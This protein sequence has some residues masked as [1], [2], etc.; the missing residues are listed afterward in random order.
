MIN[1]LSSTCF[2]ADYLGLLLLMY[3]PIGFNF[4]GTTIEVLMAI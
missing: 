4:V 1:E 3:K 2:K